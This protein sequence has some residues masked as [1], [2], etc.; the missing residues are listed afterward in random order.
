M[1]NEKDEKKMTFEEYQNKY[2]KPENLKSAKNF[3]ILF[4]LAIGVIIFTCLFFI[5]LKVY[6]INKIAGYVAT[7]VAV[8][9]YLIVYIIPVIRIN[10]VKSF[11]VNV[12]EMN[13][14]N[15]IKHN[16]KLREELADKM[17]DL[18][19]KID[20]VSFYNNE[21][22]G[23]LA[24]ARQTNNNDNLKSILTDIYKTDVKKASNKMIR[25]HAVKVGFT[26]A[27][28]Q[29]EKLD[30]LFVLIYDLQLI[31]DI[32]FLYGFRPSDAKMVKIYKTVL[33]SALLSYGLGEVTGSVST[34]VVKKLSK[35]VDGIPVIGS[36]AGAIIDSS[37]QGV[38]NSS[39]TV[40][41]GFQTR[42][43]LMKEYKLQNILDNVIIDDEEEE[44]EKIELITE[45]EK[46]VKP[47]ENLIKEK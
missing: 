18:H 15:A 31:K 11:D 7:G 36:A 20:N 1:S 46:E 39:F 41:V 8:I 19:S 38:I 4:S 44:K 21:N 45:V 28:S 9:I 2:S 12:D 10:N 17:I 3:L 22:I 33:C 47:K 34:G 16:K 30:T 43:Y 23:R 35:F 40:I 5:V 27:L 32:V 25:D 42:K 6:D 24:I 14:K 37:L 29:S 13:Y 26:T